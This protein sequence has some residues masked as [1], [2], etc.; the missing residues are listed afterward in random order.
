MWRPPDE[1]EF[2]EVA[3]TQFSLIGCFSGLPAKLTSRGTELLAAP[4]FD[5]WRSGYVRRSLASVASSR[6]VRPDEVV[7]LP[8]RRSFRYDADPFGIQL[9]GVLTVFVENYDYR[10]RR[11]EIHYCQYDGADRLLKQGVALTQAVHLSYP[12]LIE[13]AGELYMLPE[14]YKSGRLTLFRCKRFPDDWEPVQQLLPEG[15][16]DATVVRYG[17]IWWMFH[18]LPGP[19]NRSMRELHI[20]FAPTLMGPWSTHPANPVRSGFE[21]SRP[22]GTAFEYDGAL[23]LPVQDCVG[24]YGAALSLLRIDVLTPEAFSAAPTIRLEP[25]ELLAGFGDGL[26]TLSGHGDITFID[27]KSIRRSFLQPFISLLFKLRRAAGL[28]KPR[29]TPSLCR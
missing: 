29:A 26:H 21:S 20:A 7:W 1:I 18:A 6:G 16:I 10:V 19:R 2:H 14:A 13:D 24:T 9:D 17:G 27:V 22:G 8:P 23:H 11:G 3:G 12:S 25:G 5:I 4:M 28:N 15:A